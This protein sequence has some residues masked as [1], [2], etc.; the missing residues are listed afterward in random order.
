MIWLYRIAF[1]PAL[2]I[3]LPY[4][5]LR[6]W[7][8]GGYGD[9]F[10]HRFGK[11]PQTPKNKPQK[12]IWLQAVSVGEVNA[13]G[14][15]IE[16]LQQTGSIEIVLTT[17][18]ST[19]YALAIKRYSG[20]VSQISIFPLDFWLCSRTA[21]KRIQP[22]AIILT[23]SELWPEHIRQAKQRQV[24]IFLI[25]ARM[26]DR[27][28]KRYKKLSAISRRLWNQIDF[29]Y[30][31][32]TEDL[33][34]LVDLGCNPLTTAN[35]GNIKFDVPILPLLSTEEIAKMRTELGFDS[36]TPDD[37][38]PFILLG[39]STWP[40]EEAALIET[41]KYLNEQGVDC[42]L[43]LVPRHAERASEIVQLLEKL[44]LNWQQRSVQKTAT[45]PLDIY[46][47]DT[48]G[49][50]T[51]LTQIADIAF[52][53]KSLPPHT[54]GQTPIEAA[55]LGIPTVTG[56]GMSNFKD[57]VKSLKQAQAAI[58]VDSVESLKRTTLALY[59]N[60]AQRTQMS[61]AGKHW[62]QQN[63]GSTQRIAES[64]LAELESESNVR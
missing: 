15:L 36:K 57:V 58:T 55:G 43:L 35:T 18:T 39:S 12:R 56:T 34:R 49:E 27:S 11:L 6:M 50:L 32:S 54:Q 53:G 8:R 5:L 22:D 20:L 1:L 48:T 59:Q 30:A 16:T 41:H 10:S 61:E 62:H 21:W 4:Y 40:Q 25:N 31:S 37:A 17:T 44:D 64:I 28:F 42:R 24:P 38:K 60:K 19:G 7:K 29:I 23:E 45:Q 47:A 46:L 14:P 13:I 52:I 63:R 33:N 3:A 2:L 26:S 51:R 9:G